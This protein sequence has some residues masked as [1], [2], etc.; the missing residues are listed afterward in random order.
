MSGYSVHDPIQSQ[1]KILSQEEES[2]WAVIYGVRFL[3]NHNGFFTDTNW[4]L[5]S[6]SQVSVIHLIILDGICSN[7]IWAHIVASKTAY[8]F[9]VGLRSEEF[10][11]H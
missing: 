11:S 9:T 1:Q 2:A 10:R 7:T 4:E 5:L 8:D 3:A 6:W